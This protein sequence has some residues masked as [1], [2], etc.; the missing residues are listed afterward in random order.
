VLDSKFNVIK[1]LPVEMDE[2]R[3]PEHLFY[4]PVSGR[5]LVGMKSG[6]V[7]VYDVRS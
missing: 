7:D 5:L 4:D 3:G 6:H 1:V 2:A